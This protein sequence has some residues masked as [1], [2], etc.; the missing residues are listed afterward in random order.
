MKRKVI[1]LI[2]F[3]FTLSFIF[4]GCT[5]IEDSEESRALCE[6][7]LGYIIQNDFEAAYG[8][9]S[10]VAS[11]EDFAYVWN[12]MR[13]VMQNSKSYEIQQKN[14]YKSWNN[15]VTTTQTLFEVITDDGKVCQFTIYT[16]DQIDGLA[17]IH[18]LD[19]TEFVRKTAFLPT[20]NIFLAIFSLACIAF[21][22]W[23]LVDCLKR[24]L[25]YKAL[26]AILTLAHAGIS[27]QAGA[28]GFDFNFK[29]M[30][31]FPF[32]RVSAIPSALAVAVTAFIPLGAIIY[33][34]IR[35]RLTLPKEI[36]EEESAS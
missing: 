2:C 35:K 21:S 1:L 22:V 24:R 34:F 29:F 11:E 36:K 10:H 15:G 33:C 14:W 19:S 16:M 8:M 28:T 23:M 27:V 3:I 17:R 5:V 26:W 30:L 7:M 4:G 31:A 20:L 6:E 9:I 18:F 13:N 32:T 12:E 25:K